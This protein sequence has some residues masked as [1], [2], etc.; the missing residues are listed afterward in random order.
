[1]FKVVVYGV[2]IVKLECGH[3]K[4]VGIYLFSLRFGEYYRLVK[5]RGARRYFFEPF[6]VINLLF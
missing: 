3:I 4:F 2:Y 6:K 5:I 1:M